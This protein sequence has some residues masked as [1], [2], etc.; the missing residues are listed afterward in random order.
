MAAVDE[1]KQRLDIIELIS[2]YMPLQKSGAN[3]KGL[4]PFHTEKTP[5]FIVFPSSQTWHC[6]GAC[7]TGGDILTFVMRR[8][9]VEFAEALKI[10]ADKAGIQLTP[11]SPRQLEIQHE[12]E[13]LW[14][15]N[16]A[17]SQLY[18]RFLLENAEAEPARSY[19]A[20]RGVSTE[21]INMFQLGYAPDRW[22]FLEDSFEGLY[23][24]E[25]MV[26]AGLLV[27][28]E[29]GNKYDRFRSRLIFPIRDEHAH[30]I[31]FAGR[32]LDD[33]LPK[34]LNTSQTPIFDKGKVLYGIDQAR[35]SIRDSGQ[36]II[37]E[38]YM[39]VIITH[40]CGIHNVVAVM[41]TALTD[42]HIESLR[43]VND[44][45]LALDPDT[46]GIHATERGYEVARTN[47]E[48]QVVPVPTAEGLVRYEEKLKAAIR[49]LEL[50]DGLDP[51][52]LVLRDR[53][54]WDSLIQKAS[55]VVEYF[56]GQFYKS[57]DLTSAKGKSAAVKRILELVA[58]VGDPVERTHYLRRVAEMFQADE[59]QLFM[60]LE[61][62]RKK[63][64]QALTGTHPV[65]STPGN[66]PEALY[67]PLT[68]QSQRCLALYLTNPVIA[69]EVITKAA[70]AVET[71]RAERDRQIVTILLQH[72]ELQNAEQ[73]SGLI[74]TFDTD[75]GMYVESVLQKLST[76]P[77]NSTDTF[78]EDLYKTTLRLKR[79]YLAERVLELQ[80]AQQQVH[81][82]GNAE[83][84]REIN[85][86]AISLTQELRQVDQLM[87]TI[88]YSGRRLVQSNRVHGRDEGSR[89]QQ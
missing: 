45:V 22:H 40:Q 54:R 70:L 7:G 87:L 56:I 1:I 47:L 41:G 39:D 81:L 69:C 71:F 75:L 61:K 36:V 28:N 4:C 58:T 52:E 30:T 33:T 12:F 80:Y 19:L 6:F 37:V 63:T 48:H 15:A 17:A 89:K 35:N 79:S 23:S 21:S 55:P 16:A 46:A 29:A 34:Y 31:G 20:R 62:L 44:L 83:R 27:K 86:L 88:S 53:P 64:A 14:Q 9:R 24:V 66:P 82:E 65:N 38:G 2:S 11:P 51:D 78:R 49:V 60:E 73:A 50:P 85:Q 25:T 67:D 57:A 43:H 68:E 59:R 42:N 10:L 77:Q 13:E 74:N 84:E 8:E 32:V 72:P 3:Y 18:H 26:T 5:S 76:G